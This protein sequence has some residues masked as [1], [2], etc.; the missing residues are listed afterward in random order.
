MNKTKD[1][2]SPINNKRWFN[3]RPLCIILAFLVIGSL[4]A[5]YIT[6]NVI[7]TIIISIIILTI[8]LV[9]SILKRKIKY[10]LVPLFSFVLGLSAFYIVEYNYN[11]GINY[12]P[13]KITAR[14]YNFDKS[15]DGYIEVLVDNCIFDN[16]KNN[17]RMVIQI[18]DKDNLF[19]NLDLGSVI[20]F[21]PDKFEHLSLYNNRDIPN[22]YYVNKN[23]KYY[24]N[25]NYNT[26]NIIRQDLTFAEKIKEYIKSNLS[27]GLSNENVEIAYSALFGDKASLSDSQYSAYKLSGVAHLLAVSGLHVGIIAGILYKILDLLKVKRWGRVLIV[28]LILLLYMYICGFSVSVVRATIM[29]LTLLIAPLVFRQYDALSATALA[30]IIVFF[31]NPMC[32]FDISTLMSFSCV[33]GIILLFRPLAKMLSHSKMPKSLI[34]SLAISIATMISLMMVMAYF[35]NTLNLISIIANIL[36]IPL[37]SVSFSIVFVLSILSL[38]FPLITHLLFVINPIFDFINLLAAILGN[39]PISNLSTID[40]KYIGIIV[41]F[42]ILLVLSRICVAGHKEKVIL[43]LPLLA[44]LIVCLL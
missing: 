29:T 37:F 27:D 38:I 9:I 6:R 28:A 3:Y 43:T 24:S 26:I 34:D 39:M 14:I 18:Y 21:I 4:F 31:I 44:L 23:I 17:D 42:I 7:V 41:Y 1:K 8:S 36:L 16:D 35:F 40:F 32:V 11:Q 13:N 25:T 2:I 12:S 33:F 22:C 15:H 5:Y 20:S 10:I 30:G 19:T